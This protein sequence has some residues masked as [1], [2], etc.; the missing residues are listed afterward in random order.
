M[1]KQENWKLA[2]ISDTRVFFSPTGTFRP[3]MIRC[4]YRA[5]YLHLYDVPVD[6]TYEE[7]V[8]LLRDYPDSSI[9]GDHS[10]KH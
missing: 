1:L 7:F 3:P 5:P 4:T 6:V 8:A 9:S 2:D 10:W